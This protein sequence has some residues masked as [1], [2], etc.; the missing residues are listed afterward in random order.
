MSLGKLF[1]L[2]D[3][4]TILRMLEAM[5][6]KLGYSVVGSSTRGSDIRQAIESHA[7]MVL[8]DIHLD[9][10][11]S[12]IEAAR[13][14]KKANVPY[15]FI[16]ADD[17][18]DTV[19]SAKTTEPYGYLMK[20]ISSSSLKAALELALYRRTMEVKL[21]E[22]DD[23]LK[24]IQRMD[25]IGRFAG[26]MAHEFNSLLTVMIG[27]SK[28]AQRQIGQSSPALES[29]VE[30]D[31]AARKAAHL[32][33]QILSFSD[34]QLLDLQPTPVDLMLT[35]FSKFISPLLG[36]KFQL[37]ITNSAHGTSPRL[38][39]SGIEQALTNIV[40][41]ASEAMPSGGTI[42]IAA[43]TQHEAPPQ[44]PFPVKADSW[45]CLSISDSGI[46]IDPELL[47]RIFDPFISTKPSG[48]GHG[49]G[50]A[51]AYGIVRQHNGWI[52]VDSTPGKGS[53]FSIL[54]PTCTAVAESSSSEQAQIR[55]ETILIAEDTELLKKMLKTI[56]T[57]MGYDVITAS[58]GSE[59]IDLFRQNKDKIRLIM[60]D[61]VMPRKGGREVY[62]VLHREALGVKFLMTSGY[63]S[64]ESIRS[65]T[66][67]HDV[68]LI[69][70]PYD[71]E[72]L[73]RK[74]QQLLN[75]N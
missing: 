40:I 48:Q 18:D 11:K 50:L 20:P 69:P 71:P 61:M 68:P 65:F 6:A 2:E 62:E 33:K 14:L 1:I 5:V 43:S 10:R 28:F 16:T 7:D 8:V 24:R 51:I 66:E 41:N 39:V 17:N 44:V 47:G 12:G 70:K 26:G 25:S 31:K 54:L 23:Q 13:I 60:L 15:I 35:R 64:D 21:R 22:K 72:E 55:G 75:V 34:H 32:T 27:Y 19:S 52:N 36:E 37:D 49:L 3:D 74:I 4:E 53:T 67:M 57:D 59:A 30:I 45:L 42:R 63:T 29:L 73:G 58:D 38:D 46:G 9:G 56:L